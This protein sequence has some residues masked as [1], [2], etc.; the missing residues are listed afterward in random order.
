MSSWLNKYSTQGYKSSSPDKNNAY[1]VIPSGRITMK[2]VPHPVYGIDNFGNSKLMMPDQEYNFPGL[3]VTEFPIKQNGGMANAGKKGN[4]IQ[5]YPG[6]PEDFVGGQTIQNPM[7]PYADLPRDLAQKLMERDMYK[8]PPPPMPITDTMNPM[9]DKDKWITNNTNRTVMKKN[10]GAAE[11]HP[12]M[13]WDGDKWVSSKGG[14][15]YSNGV[16]FANGGKYS[17]NGGATFPIGGAAPVFKGGGPVPS[18]YIDGNGRPVPFAMTPGSGQ[19]SGYLQDLPTHM[20][21]GGF[22]DENG[23]YV[24]PFAMAPGDGSGGGMLEKYAAEMMKRGGHHSGGGKK[25][26][27]PQQMQ[28]MMQAMG[29][30][31]PMGQPPGG[32]AVPMMPPG[33]GAG[34]MMAPQA[35]MPQGG[36]MMDPGQQP[37]KSGGIHIKPSHKGR[38]TAYK[39]RTGKTTEE[40]LH[41]KDPHVRQMANFA[42]NAK[43]WHHE[44]GGPVMEDGGITQGGNVIRDSEGRVFA[45]GGMVNPYHP[46]AKFMQAGGPHTDWSDPSEEAPAQ[47]PQQGTSSTQTGVVP[48]ASMP[49]TA[50]ENPAWRQG[51]NNQQAQENIRYGAGSSEAYD[52]ETGNTRDDNTSRP[53]QVNDW[54]RFGVGTVMGGLDVANAYSTLGKQKRDYRQGFV[55]HQSSNAFAPINQPDGHGDWDQYG[56]FRRD[57]NVPTKPGMFYPSMKMGGGVPMYQAGGEY[58]VDD[59]EIARLKAMGYKFEEL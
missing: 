14:A 54:M 2:D 27:S 15:T 47:N 50:Q 8:V 46:L 3:S 6:Q 52:P 57:R 9:A 25:K 40:A 48:Q 4:L 32:G 12:G 45:Y 17:Q 21:A 37:M 30:G 11:G 1:N 22:T 10:G 24:A 13:F 44:T 18:F 59:R 16:F 23:E 31:Q 7:H 58:N 55:D 56:A 43:K 38:F 53:G 36:Q 34:Q 19:G 5:T 29:A 49:G 35:M 41:S 33:G 51:M 42:R 39:E 20:R 28:M 26:L